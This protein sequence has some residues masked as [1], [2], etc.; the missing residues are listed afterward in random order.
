MGDN[1]RRYNQGTRAALAA[2][3]RGTCYFPECERQII[4]FDDLGEPYID[5]QIAHIYDAN[6]GN[7][8]REDMTDME[9]RDFSNLILLCKPHHERVDKRHPDNYP[10]ETLL[11][12][13]AEH[14]AGGIAA[15]SATGTIDENGLAEQL[16][17]VAAIELNDAVINLGGTGGSALGAGGGGGAVIGL[18]FGGPGGLGG[19]INLD[20]KPGTAPGAGGGG[21]GAFGP[22]AFGGEGGG[23]GEYVASRRIPVEPGD[24]LRFHVGEGGKE[25]RDGEDTHVEHVNKDGVVTEIFRAK[26]GVAGRSGTELRDLRDGP[27]VKITSA[28]L[29][30]VAQVK[31]GLL[32]VWGGGWDRVEYG[33]VPT[34]FS[35]ALVF[36][37]EVLIPGP[38]D[39]ELT[40]QLI[41]SDGAVRAKD[42]FPVTYDAYPLPQRLVLSHGFND[43]EVT[44]PGVWQITISSAAQLLSAIDIRLVIEPQPSDVAGS[45]KR[46]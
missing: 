42:A 15:L 44:K 23:G 45:E 5:Y 3:S 13:K 37:A 9:R 1:A 20:G 29:C 8:Y 36:I 40:L 6:V 7:R 38:R 11:A 27:S 4:V 19:N 35:C 12:W 41:D 18:G 25:G 21:G 10:P 28:F 30:D 16:Q 43:H 33:S 31:N 17:E 2:L 26:G 22:D 14:E 39:T 34:A 24:Q 46:E 32:N